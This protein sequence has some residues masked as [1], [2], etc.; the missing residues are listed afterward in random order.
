MSA[1]FHKIL[2][3]LK[4]HGTTI[5]L[6]SHDLTEVQS[7]CDRV[8]II[9]DGKMILVE[10]VSKLKEKFLQNVNIKFNTT[11]IPSLE[12]ILSVPSVLDVSKIS[13]TKFSLKINKNINEFL[14]FITN[15]D[16]ERMSIEES[17]LEEIFL[18]FYQ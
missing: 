16:V 1:T 13:D 17:S 7:I 9:K 11:N 2:R 5:L 14:R 8:G 12:E 18:H 10:D 15:Y 4:E 6:S 3:Q